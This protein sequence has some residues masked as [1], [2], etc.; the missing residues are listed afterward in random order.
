MIR[1]PPRSTLFPYTTLFRSPVPAPTGLA[2]S[3]KL[4]VAADPTEA[5]LVYYDHNNRFAG[6]SVEL[7]GEIAS[8][9]ALKLNP[10]NIDT[11]QIVPG[12]ADVQ[13]R[14]DIGVASQPATTDTSA[15]A[16]TL[17]YLI[18]GQA[19]LAG[20][21]QGAVKALGDLCGLTLGANPGNAGRTAALR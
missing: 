21:G 6:F 11:S 8:E 12:L 14:Y 1:R 10:I 16:L 15:S 13:H 19:I 20:Q 17:N 7:L 4:T 9:M 3:G 2:N 5:A 18:G